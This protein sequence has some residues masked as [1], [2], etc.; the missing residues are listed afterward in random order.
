[1]LKWKARCRSTWTSSTAAPRRPDAVFRYHSTGSW[2]GT[3]WNYNNAEVDKLLD[4]AR[5][6]ADPV[7]Q[8]KLY[9]RFQEIVVK[10]GPGSIVLVSNFACGISKKVQGFA[11]SPLMFA[12]ISQVTLAS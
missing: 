7:E 9:G 8:A 12:D 2:N 4:T 10:D 1:M 11:P 6:I 3:P 5:T